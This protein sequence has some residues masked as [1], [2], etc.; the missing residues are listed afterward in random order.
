MASNFIYSSRDHKFILREWLGIEKILGFS[1]YRDFYD[2]GDVDVLLDQALKVAREVVAPTN[3][4]GEN[5]GVK[6]VDGQVYVPPSFHKAH[7][8]MQE[9]GWGMSDPDEEGHMPIVIRAACSEYF[10]AANPAFEPYFGLAA[11]ASRLIATFGEPQDKERFLPKMYGGEWG[12]TMCLTEPGAGSDVGASTTKAYPTDEPRIYKIK[13]TKCFITGGDHDL[14]E[15]IIHLLLAR[16]DGAAPG[17]KGISLFIVP[18][19]WVDENGRM[20]GRN[21]VTTVAIEHKLGLKGSATA[22]LNFG[23]EG[24]C[25]GILLG[26][27]PDENG[28]AEGMAQMFQMMNSARHGTGHSALYVATVAY[29]NAVQYAKERIQGKALTNP[30]GPAVPIIK[31]EDVRR[32]LLRQK[33]M[34]EAMRALIFKNWYYIEVAQNSDDE[35]EREQA[36]RNIQVL[37]PLGKAY[38]SDLAW[39]LIADAIQVYGG[40]GFSEEY[41]VARQARDCKI[42]SI[43]E[44]T[45]YIQSMD[46]VGRKWRLEKGKL[47]RDWMAEL[48]GF[49]EKNQGTGGLEREFAILKQAFGSFQEI[50]ATIGKYFM[51][52]V[53][54]VPVFSTRVLHATSMVYCGALM[55][56]QAMVA[57][58]KLT[59]VGENHPDHV[60]YTGKIQSAKYYIRNVVPGVMNLAQVI[61]DGDTSVLDI[62]EEAF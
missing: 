14:T 5:I 16:I 6:L 9:N 4:D 53:S 17:T 59:Q 36:D 28:V 57:M 47:F 39:E 29:N 55:A 7:K 1:A 11:G 24:E 44:G 10:G 31:H 49:I 3:D 54:L 48:G 46:L 25:R 13:G 41:P 60:F 8:F 43:W 27:P 18:K 33:A 21:D 15:N 50:Y 12:G 22:M 19:F 40:Y 52:Q 62:P 38:C 61:K 58:D 45:N 34:L 2:V 32:M 42:Y 30:K 35:K 51:S 26:K 20:G 37:N 56:E 23:D